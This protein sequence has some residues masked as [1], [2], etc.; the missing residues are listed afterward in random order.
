MT[1]EPLRL[2]DP[3]ALDARTSARGRAS[4][5]VPTVWLR[6][7]A[8]LEVDLPDRLRCDLCDG[9]GCDACARSGG[10]LLPVVRS[11]LAIT[12]PRVIDDH[13]ALR[14]TNPLGDVTPSLLVVHIACGPMASR[15]VRYLGP[16]HD[17][18]L[19]GS[20][21]VLRAMD[22]V[23]RWIKAMVIVIVATVLAL[24]ARRFVG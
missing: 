2:L 4:I 18:A 21:A 20:I 14:V 22:R 9:G 1:D 3:D 24:L 11:A 8:R 10:Y 6:D 19:G 13:I 5:V 23:P 12:L 17:D 16:H 7:G 15:G